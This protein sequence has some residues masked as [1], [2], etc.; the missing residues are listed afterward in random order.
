MARE[1]VFTKI[2][3]QY[4]KTYE[5]C[6]KVFEDNFLNVICL[7]DDEKNLFYNFMHLRRRTIKEFMI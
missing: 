7:S 4:P 2:Q 6:C 5:E 3:P 1:E